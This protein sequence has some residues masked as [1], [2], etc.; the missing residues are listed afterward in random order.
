MT[1]DVPPVQQDVFSKDVIRVHPRRIITW[2]LT[3]RGS[4]ARDVG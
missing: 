2:N 1:V 3:A 4:T